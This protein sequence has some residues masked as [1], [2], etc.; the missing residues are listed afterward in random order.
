MLVTNPRR[1]NH[2]QL[3]VVAAEAKGSIKHLF[4]HWT[5]CPF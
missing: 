1:I 5:G 4:L 3:R 2:E